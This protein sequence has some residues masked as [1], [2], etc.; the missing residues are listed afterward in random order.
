MTTDNNDNT[1]RSADAILNAAYDAAMS[2]LL[3]GTAPP[4]A[5]ASASATAVK[6]YEIKKA[7]EPSSKEPA[8]MSYEEMQATIKDLRKSRSDNDKE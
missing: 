7:D 4:T 6:I 1:T 3:D 5:K 8:E 2:V